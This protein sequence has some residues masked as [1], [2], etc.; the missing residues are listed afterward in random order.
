MRKG[1]AFHFGLRSRSL[2]RES[3]LLAGGMRLTV[4]VRAS[5]DRRELQTAPRLSRQRSCLDDDRRT[6]RPTDPR[7]LWG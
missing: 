2:I 4:A 7:A 6:S 1:G 5:A 3:L